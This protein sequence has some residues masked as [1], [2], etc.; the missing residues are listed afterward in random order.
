MQQMMP[1]NSTARSTEGSHLQVNEYIS[2]PR[3][4][5]IRLKWQEIEHLH[6]YQLPL[7]S[8]MSFPKSKTGTTAFVTLQIHLR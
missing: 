3:C 6:Y 5:H 8:E 2:I 7:L 1:T 4:L